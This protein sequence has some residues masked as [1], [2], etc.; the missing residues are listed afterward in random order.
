ME[1]I[2]TLYSKD[3]LLKWINRYAGFD[4]S[5]KHNEVEVDLDYL[6]RFWNKNK[7]NL[8]HLLGDKFIFEKEIIYSE[9][10]DDL[11]EKM[12][13]LLYENPAGRAFRTN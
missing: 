12:E 2:N 1:L 10:K 7:K 9:P 5:C 13:T 8:F 11:I 3:L 4:E 6:L